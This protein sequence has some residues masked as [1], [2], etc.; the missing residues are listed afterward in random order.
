MTWS[1]NRYPIFGVMLG[2]DARRIGNFAGAAT[3]L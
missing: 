3:L 2:D 1:E